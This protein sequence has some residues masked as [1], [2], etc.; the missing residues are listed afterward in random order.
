MNKKHGLLRK[1]CFLTFLAQNQD[2]GHYLSFRRSGADINEFMLC[3][4]LCIIFYILLTW[5]YVLDLTLSTIGIGFASN[6]GTWGWAIMAWPSFPFPTSWKKFAFKFSRLWC[7]PFNSCN[8]IDFH[9][10]Y[11]PLVL[12]LYCTL[13]HCALFTVQLDTIC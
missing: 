1:L 8:F 12:L 3:N 2:P 10:L 9:I 4:K 13:L 6:F 11:Q 5:Y 7:L